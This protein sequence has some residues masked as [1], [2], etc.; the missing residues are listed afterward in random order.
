MPEKNKPTICFMRHGHTPFNSTTGDSLDSRIRG[1][2]DVP[3]DDEGKKQAKGQ[4]QKFKNLDVKEIYSSPLKRALY[5]AQAVADVTGA[6]IKSTPWLLPWDLGDWAGD[7]VR[8]HIKELEDLQHHIDK[9]P[10]GGKPF[11]EFYKRAKKIVTWLQQRAMKVGT[12]LAVS[13]S[14]LMLALP[15][16]LSDGD[17][18][19]IP[20]AGGPANS[21][22]LEIEKVDGNWA[23]RTLE[24]DLIER[25]EER[26]KKANFLS[27][28][29]KGGMSLFSGLIAETKRGM[30]MDVN[31]LTDTLAKTARILCEEDHP[32]A[33]QEL[34]AMVGD[35]DDTRA[36]TFAQF[37]PNPGTMQLPNPL[38]P[39]EGDEIFFAYMIPGAVFQAHDGSQWQIDGYDSPDQIEIYNRWYPR[40]HGVVAIG[41][42]RRSID[43]WVEPIQQTVPPPPPGVDYAALPVKIM[44]D[45]N[46][47]GAIDKVTDYRKSDQTGGW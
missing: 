33:D 13:H 37:V 8:Q 47:M 2:L 35:P 44:D 30:T 12:I 25:K 40:I 36:S 39:V 21:Q 15:C 16:I 19:T 42:I 29:E 31:E 4:A 9:A 26:G 11:E 22:V 17:P 7:P 23:L 5:T 32:N 20:L 14:R 41:D 43:Q 6:P 27:L 46:N 3:L 34:Q 1:W 38:S 28:K 24:D 45:E 10:P 18:T